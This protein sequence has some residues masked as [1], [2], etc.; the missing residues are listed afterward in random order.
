M[1]TAFS[2]GDVL[3]IAG[4]IISM[5]L[6]TVGLLLG[7]VFKG[8]NEKLRNLGQSDHDFRNM[9]GGLDNKYVPRREFEASERVMSRALDDLKGAIEHGFER[10]YAQLKEKAD[11]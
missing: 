11:R 5:L 3:M 10:V 6:T 1:T 4:A 2:V 7:H 9:V 8:I